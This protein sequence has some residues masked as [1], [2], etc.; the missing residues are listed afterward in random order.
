MR[1]LFFRA[2]APDT[3]DAWIDFAEE[4]VALFDDLF[5]RTNLFAAH[6]LRHT[7]VIARHAVH[8]ECLIRKPCGIEMLAL[9]LVDF[10][11][12][13][14]VHC[15]PPLAP[16]AEALAEKKFLSFLHCNMRG[17]ARKQDGR[18]FLY[19]RASQVQGTVAVTSPI[20]Q[21]SVAKRSSYRSLPLRGRW[22]R[23]RRKG[24][25]R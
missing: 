23:R 1:C 8:F 10:F 16:R 20:P 13:R 19:C 4:H 3:V 11:H 17:N 21:P 5:R 18:R 7:V 9:V 14:P 22:R 25:R 24:W 6:E 15:H 12:R 2:D